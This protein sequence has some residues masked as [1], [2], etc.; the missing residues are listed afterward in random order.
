MGSPGVGH[1]TKLDSIE[2]RWPDR[3]REVLRDIAVDRILQVME[4]QAGKIG[5]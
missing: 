5:R 4:G 1:V 2:I 3:R